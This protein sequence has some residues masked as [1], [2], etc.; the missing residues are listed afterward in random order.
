[1]PRLR[2]FC[3]VSDRHRQRAALPAQRRSFRT[4]AAGATRSSS[5]GTS[6][7]AGASPRVPALQLKARRERIALAGDPDS[8]CCLPPARGRTVRHGR[9]AVGQLQQGGRLRAGLPQRQPE[10]NPDRQAEP[11]RAIRKHRSVTGPAIR[12]R[13][14]FCPCPARSAA[15]RACAAGQ[16]G[17]TRSQ[18][19]G[20]WV[21]AC[22]CTP[23]CRM[24]SR[25]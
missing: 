25:C 4:T 1:M 19:A 12:R 10:Q 22:P 9:V 17:R 18:C 5:P 7:P 2:I 21:P 6:R 20:G 15:R 8:K 3:P 11:D 14:R 24:D 23:S 13:A 16:H